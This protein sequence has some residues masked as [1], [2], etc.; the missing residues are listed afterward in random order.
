[1]VI[2]KIKLGFAQKNVADLLRKRQFS[3]R[4]NPVR[5]IGILLD[6]ADAG[7]VN[8]FKV[9]KEDL[10]V[11]EED[12]QILFCYS[13]KPKTLSLESLVFTPADIGWKGNFKSPEIREF[14]ETKF[15][16]LISFTRFENQPAKLMAA[17]SDAAFKVNRKEEDSLVFDMTILTGF[18]NAGI[19]VEE[20]KKYLNI[21]NKTEE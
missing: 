4:A 14:A 7:V 16:L 12:F 3:E 5:S 11:R 2:S 1:M 15:D 13:S 8:I 10:G 9:L 19:F 17:A 20:L 18:E 6:E 21:I